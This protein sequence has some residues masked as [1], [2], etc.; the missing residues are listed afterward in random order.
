MDGPLL[1]TVDTENYYKHPVK[2]HESGRNFVE[3]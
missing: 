2:L 3:N 1:V